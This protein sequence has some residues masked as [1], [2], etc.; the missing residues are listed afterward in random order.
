MMKRKMSGILAIFCLLSLLCLPVCGAE[1]ENPEYPAVTRDFASA[2]QL[3]QWNRLGLPEGTMEI[4][5]EQLLLGS[6]TAF[7]EV[8]ALYNQQMCQDFT[9]EF[10][11]TFPEGVNN[12][13]AMFFY[14]SDALAAQGY[15]VYFVHCPDS[16]K[17]YYIKFVSRPYQDIQAGFF[18]NNDGEG[19][20]YATDAV[21]VKLVVSGATHT[22][23]M[24]VPG[25]EYG[26]PIF[27]ITEEEP[28]YSNSGYMGFMMWHDAGTHQATVAFDNL[29]ITCNDEGEAPLPTEPEDPSEVT[30]GT[31]TQ[32]FSEPLSDNWGFYRGD[33]GGNSAQVVDDLLVL[34]TV[35]GNVAGESAAY[36]KDKF[37]N[38]T[39]EA[40]VI[41]SLGNS[42][43]IVF[44]G[45]DYLRQGYQLV[46][47]RY[48][49]LSL[50]KRPYE[51]LATAADFEVAYDVVYHAKITVEGSRIQAAVTYTDD[52]NETRTVTLDYTDEANSYPDAGYVGFVNYV[53]MANKTEAYLDNLTITKVVEGTDPGPEDPDPTDPD[54]T[55][56]E[57][58]DPTDPGDSPDTGEAALPASLVV[59]AA[60][61]L[62]TAVLTRRRAHR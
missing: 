56:P 51:V 34:T 19:V 54:P 58:P 38:G 30:A 5:D 8:A 22:L 53:G 40:D 9:A 14:R 15:A 20:E 13:A 42:T 10:T 48:A 27:S 33:V 23:Y 37:Q 36:Y 43:S 21:Q 16:D 47:D 49:G 6:A 41:L 11:F 59:L 18:F 62:G 39:I 1:A 46:F 12:D 7:S 24:T 55:D 60:A 52:N 61:A 45:R 31:V 29:T 44:R 17:Q 4:Q 57:E 26:E 3:A 50:C 35:G 32:D 2:D 28:R 25:K